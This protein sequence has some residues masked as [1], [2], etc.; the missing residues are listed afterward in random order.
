ML[1]PEEIEKEMHDLA[2]S[3]MEDSIISMLPDHKSN[4]T[5]LDLWELVY[6]QMV[7]MC[8]NMDVLST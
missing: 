8:A 1:E 7:V 2:C 4:P 6:E 3:F 5:D